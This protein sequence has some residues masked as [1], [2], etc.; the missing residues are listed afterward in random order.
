M[1]NDLK[2]LVARVPGFELEKL[3]TEPEK[4][5]VALLAY[6][7]GLTV[8]AWLRQRLLEGLQKGINEQF[9]DLTRHAKPIIGFDSQVEICLN[10]LTQP[11]REALNALLVPRPEP[12]MHCLWKGT[13]ESSK[14][15]RDEAKRDWE[16]RLARQGPYRE[17]LRPTH[18]QLRAVERIGRE[19]PNLAEVTDYLLSQLRLARR[20]RL[21]LRHAPRVLLIGPPAAGKTWWAE[22]VADALDIPCNFISLANVTA[23]FELSGGSTQWQ[24]GKPGRI[25]R[26]FMGTKSAS[27]LIVLDEIDK[28]LRTNNYPTADSL[29]DLVER[30]SATRWYD[31]FYSRSFDV[32]SAILI[33]TANEADRIDVPLRS[34]FQTF[35]VKAPRAD[36]RLAMVRSV[37]RSYRRM[38]H[39]LILPRTL[40]EAVVTQIAQR[41]EDAREVMRELDRALA[42][43]SDRS[44]R[45]R[46]T[47]TDLRARMASLCMPEPEEGGMRH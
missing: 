40:D 10:R 2:D 29:L 8:D 39:D 36:Q 5:L 33:A 12:N 25:V 32:S 19:A 3:V 27:P 18:A 20:S 4:A 37:W 26:S 13:I 44:G 38:R 9:P 14:G 30:S 47:V 6:R 17:Y 24:S 23:N 7:E 28:A 46:I 15:Y 43:A 1:H 21:G 35:H 41:A 16:S 42:N 45:I 31:E 11:T 22:Q 34:R